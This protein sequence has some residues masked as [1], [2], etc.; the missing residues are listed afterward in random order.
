M[1]TLPTSDLNL[2]VKADIGVERND[3]SDSSPTYMPA[4]HRDLVARWKDQVIGG[5]KHLV[6]LKDVEQGAFQPSYVDANGKT[7]VCVDYWRSG[8][9]GVNKALYLPSAYAMNTRS[10]T[11]IVVV[12]MNTVDRNNFILTVG[13]NNPSTA[14]MALIVKDGVL[15][16]WDGGM[17]RDTTLRV[18]S[19]KCVIVWRCRSDG[20]DVYLN[21]TSQVATFAAATDTTRNGGEV[22]GADGGWFTAYEIALYSRA[23]NA[24]EIGDAIAYALARHSIEVAPTRHVIIDGDDLSEGFGATLNQP[25]WRLLSSHEK[26]YV[27]CHAKSGQNLKTYGVSPD[28]VIPG[29]VA[30][31]AEI[32]A[33]FSATVED[34]L[35]CKLG[36]NDIFVKNLSGLDLYDALVSYC[37]ARKA[38]ATPA[39]A[40]KVVVWTISFLTPTPDSDT[41]QRDAF[42]AKIRLDFTVPTGSPY[43]LAAKPGT[44]YADY[45]VDIAAHPLI[46]TASAPGAPYWLFVG[47]NT[48]LSLTDAG[49]ALEV[50]MIG[51]G[52]FTGRASKVQGARIAIPVS[53]GGGATIQ[54]ITEN[55]LPTIGRQQVILAVYEDP[56]GDKYRTSDGPTSIAIAS[57]A[58]GTLATLSTVQGNIQMFVATCGDDGVIKLTWT[59]PTNPTIKSYLGV[60]APNGR[61]VMSTSMSGA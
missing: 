12:E 22:G 20:I 28:P 14:N 43:I 7:G 40:D 35:F 49:Y 31:A 16:V 19:S 21:S 9:Q 29:A 11:A 50:A 24:I 56:R 8:S 47:S 1:A 10:F 58:S 46:G 27:T 39:P 51:D 18:P 2:W 32:D 25:Y 23:L 38:A 3:G 5:N 52:I 4:V 41:A 42:N 53:T 45:L 48:Y 61:V 36:T 26:L 60:I 57:G 59:N 34:W 55:G 17:M 13:A 30:D 54:L 33:L 37:Q 6:Q 44:T 15:H